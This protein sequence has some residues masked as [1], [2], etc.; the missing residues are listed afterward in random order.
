MLWTKRELL[1]LSRHRV[2]AVGGGK[3]YGLAVETGG[4]SVGRSGSKGH[5]SARGMVSRLL[6]GKEE[7]SLKPDRSGWEHVLAS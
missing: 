3:N 6:N 4:T 2:G 7:A 5:S 1:E